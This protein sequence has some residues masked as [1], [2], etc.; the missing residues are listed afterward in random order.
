MRF[1][2]SKSLTNVAF[3]D[4]LG[5]RKGK[6]GKKKNVA[7]A[8]DSEGHLTVETQFAAGESGSDVCTCT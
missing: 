3:L 5:K 1:R 8:T 6:K 2:W 7:G 4:D